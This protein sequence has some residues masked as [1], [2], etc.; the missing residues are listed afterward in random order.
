M[1]IFNIEASDFNLEEDE[2]LARFVK[3][4]PISV[5]EKIEQKIKEDGLTEEIKQFILRYVNV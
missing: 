5:R 3:Y 1:I 2:S 4:L